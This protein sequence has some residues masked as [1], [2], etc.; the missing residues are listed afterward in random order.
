MDQLYLLTFNCNKILDI[1]FVEKLLKTFPEEIPCLFLFGFQEVCSIQDSMSPDTVN[2]YLIAINELLTKVIYEK[3]EVQVHTV[4]IHHVGAV[5][6]IVLT[7]YMSKIKKM[8][9]GNYSCGMSW[10]SLKGGCGARFYYEEEEFTI[11]AL[12]LCANEG[13]KN[14]NTRDQNSLKLLSSIDFGDGYGVFKPKNH[15]FFMGDLNYRQISRVTDRSSVPETLLSD[16]DPVKDE[17]L[18]SMERKSAF[19]G[20]QEAQI[21]F[22]PTYKFFNNSNEY[23]PKRIPSW[24]DR[25]LYLKYLEKELRINGYNVVPDVLTSDH[26]PVYLD[27]EVPHKAPLQELVDPKGYLIQ[28][29]SIFMKPTLSSKL[30]SGLTV[31]ADYTLFGSLYLALTGRGRIIL[32]LFALVVLVKLLY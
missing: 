5:G 21:T 30:Q 24:C 19:W 23:N 28:D 6:L 26:H 8:R 14:W 20:F 15:I 17:L 18:T 3:Y 32:S 25:I 11:V 31:V 2:K 16:F 22:K 27:I 9:T 1:G 13:V 10:S 29:N 4:A 12:H 7:P